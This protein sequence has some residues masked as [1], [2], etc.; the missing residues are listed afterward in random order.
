M[1]I[2]SGI[3]LL[4]A[5]SVALTGLATLSGCS[6][7]EDATSNAPT[8]SVYRNPQA[9]YDQQIKSVFGF[10]SVARTDALELFVDATTA[11]IKVVDKKNNA[12]WYSNPQ[13][14]F[15]GAGTGGTTLDALASQVK[16]EYNVKDNTMTYNTCADAVWNNQFCFEQVE[17][18]L[19]VNYLLGKPVKT[20]IVP[21][22]ISVERHEEFASVLTEEQL[23][24]LD[25]YYSYTSLDGM[26]KVESAVLTEKYPILKKKDV[27]IALLT[28]N[29][30]SAD[31]V[32]ASD[33]LMTQLEEIFI[34]A[35]YTEEKYVADNEE[36]GITVSNPDDASIALSVVYSIADG[37]FSAVIPNDSITYDSS[38]VTPMNFTLLPYFGCA[39]DKQNGYMF[40]PD[41]TG[42]L[43]NLNNGKHSANDYSKRVY[44]QDY[45]VSADDDSDL[46]IEQIY[47]PV[48]GMRQNNENGMQG[49]LAVIEKGDALAE[50]NA[51]ISGRVSNF[52]TICS[53]FHAN[54]TQK[55]SEQTL[56]VALGRRYQKQNASSDFAIRY[57]FLGADNTDY[58]GMA[59]RYREYLLAANGLNAAQVPAKMPLYISTIGAVDA[60]ETVAGIPVETLV[61]LTTYEQNTQIMQKLLDA[62]VDTLLWNTDAW[63][64]NGVKNTAFAKLSLPGKLGGKG[65]YQS[66]LTFAKDKG[67]IL[68]PQVKL[69][70]V[71]KET[72]FDGF[73]GSKHVARNLENA[74]AYESDYSLVTRSYDEETRRKLISAQA[75]GE[76]LN[77]FLSA[78]TKYGNKNIGLST[79]GQALNGDYNEDDFVDRQ[80]AKDLVAALLADIPEDLFLSAQGGNAYTLGV[81][82]LIHGMP[83]ISS[84]EYVFDASVP[85]YQM[86]VRGFIPYTGRA[87]NL[88]SE[89]EVDVL[90]L[91]ETGTI[92][93][94]QWIYEQ[95]TVLKNTDYNY[96][97]VNYETWLEKAVALYEE[98]NTALAGLADAEIVHHEMLTADV[99]CTEYEGGVKIYVNYGDT[100][101]KTADG[102]VQP[103]DYLR[104]G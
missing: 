78:Y 59:M 86:V 8:K 5:L 75:Y 1:K 21:Q 9:D 64:N 72:S 96:Y 43:I 82:D 65:D 45:S 87:M 2:K 38:Y 49:F 42:A 62:G 33:Y 81:L 39:S 76:M 18:G 40:V 101:Y 60:V 92:P 93:S 104:V 47:L 69:Q 19:R 32:F 77:G 56:G 13:D 53:V 102:T 57:L 98:I 29:L 95:N 85:F 6:S 68:Y 54:Q 10:Q 88:S 52:N 99:V 24:F 28:N 31:G 23:A 73:S 46:D 41:G 22:I 27:Y 61:P 90:R 70:A 74:T 16:V 30:G 55:A 97:S 25:A 50:I 79:L 15:D 12:E 36:N 26:S 71:A 91:I 83:T 103:T 89:Y 37:N 3:S 67:I 63:C 80:Q 17:D 100:A 14:R 51:S 34:A 44:G 35:G 66:L 84:R 94:F 7:H 4:L 20:Y 58:N 11:E 48:F